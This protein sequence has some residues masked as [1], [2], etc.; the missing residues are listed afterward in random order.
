VISGFGINS[1]CNSLFQTHRIIPRIPDAICGPHWEK[2][3]EFIISVS[4]VHRVSYSVFSPFWKI[5]IPTARR[6]GYGVLH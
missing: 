1:I 2:R 6:L 4:N 5:R 3:L